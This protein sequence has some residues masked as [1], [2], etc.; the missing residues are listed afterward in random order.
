MDALK[1]LNLAMRY[2]EEH[3]TEEIDVQK[4][5]S[6]ACC[7]EYHLKRMFSFLAGFPLSEYIRCRRLS[8]AALAL[9]TGGA[10]VIDLAMQ[11]GYV[12]RIPFQ[13]RS[14]RFTELRQRRREKTAQ[15]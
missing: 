1:R 4:A 2:M 15:P 5:A 10:K 11:Y 7:S 12:R 8:L 9:Q 6:I 14:M 3:L 13:G